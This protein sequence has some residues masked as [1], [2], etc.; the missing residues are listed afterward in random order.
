M[1]LQVQVHNFLEAW[2]DFLLFVWIKG[3]NNS[4]SLNKL[5]ASGFYRLN[6]P[7]KR[8]SLLHNNGT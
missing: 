5:H 6:I 4:V 1:A 8:F 3:C 7:V 2:V